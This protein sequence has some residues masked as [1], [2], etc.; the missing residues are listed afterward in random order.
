M[1]FNTQ[2]NT[3]FLCSA[4]GIQTGL[5]VFSLEVVEIKAY[6]FGVARICSVK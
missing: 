5:K 1:L 2:C 3:I 4:Y 6:I